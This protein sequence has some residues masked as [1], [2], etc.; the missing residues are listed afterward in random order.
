MVILTNCLSES[1][2]EGCLKVA[3]SLSKRIK[4]RCPSTTIMSYDRRPAQTD[5]HLRLN[6]LFLNVRLYSILRE[7]KEAVLYIPFSSCSKASILRTFILSR[8]SKVPVNVLFVGMKPISFPYKQ[9]L[10]LS[11]ANILC[12]SRETEEYFLSFIEKKVTYLKTG[13]DIS[14]FCPITEKEKRK[15]REDYGIEQNEKVLMHVGHLNEGRNIR[16]LMDVDEGFRVVL[17]VSTETRHEWDEDLRAE[18]N[19]CPNIKIVDNYV[20]KIEN[21]YRMSDIYFFPVVDSGHCIDTPLSVL[22]AAACGIPVVTTDYAELKELV[23]KEGFYRIESFDKEK[24]NELIYKA[25]SERKNG[26][27]SVMAYSWDKAVDEI[28]SLQ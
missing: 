6:K 14:R 4:K 1:P 12:I 24:I 18:L 26:R 27:S 8:L 19:K 5:C 28:L 17:V 3:S 9:L 2:D 16:S 13:V 11:K 20:E 22:E 23:D 25:Y 21:L 15:L 7:K 10:R